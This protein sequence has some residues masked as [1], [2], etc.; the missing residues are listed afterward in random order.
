MPRPRHAPRATLALLLPLVL[1]C[2]LPGGGTATDEGSA[3]GTSTTDGTSP[4]DGGTPPTD[5]DATGEDPDGSGSGSAATPASASGDD[6]TD[7]GTA[8][9]ADP[10]LSGSPVDLRS[11]GNYVLLAK[12]AI[13]TVPSSDIT[14]DLAIS[15]AA[16]SFITGF[17]LVADPTNVFSTSTQVAGKVYAANYDLPTP[18]DLTLAIG[19]MQLAFVDAAGRAPDVVELGAGDIGGLTLNPGVYRW[20]TGLLVPA[21]VT[22][23]GSATDVWIFQIGQDLTVSA[24]VAVDLT[25]GAAAHNVF[26]QVSGR[27]DLGATAHL[28]GVVLSQ[29]SITLDTGASLDGRLLAQTAISLRSNT[30]VEPTP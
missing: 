13:S 11:A 9:T 4:T 5:P 8:G 14:G 6:T 23:H 29:T 27:V 18:V 12:S 17:S 25:G 21:D 10:G 1:A 2:Q 22:L 15:P 19:D 30:V 7:S 24:D 28:A 16:A 20:G 26:W 3:S